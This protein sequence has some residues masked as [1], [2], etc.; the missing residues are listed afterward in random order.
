MLHRRLRNDDYRGVGE[1]LSELGNYLSFK[2]I[3]IFLI[4]WDG[5]G[6][7]QWV[8]H[9]LLFTKPGIIYT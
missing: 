2:Y 4:D 6:M 5:Q 7:R 9:T 8:T 1:P 3:N